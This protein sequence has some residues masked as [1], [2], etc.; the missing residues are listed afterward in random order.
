M[1][2]NYSGPHSLLI[3]LIS[4]DEEENEAIEFEPARLKLMNRAVEL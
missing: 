4:I 3:Y 2:V 1:S